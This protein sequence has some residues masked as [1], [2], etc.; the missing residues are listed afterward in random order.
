MGC[1]F[2]VVN[3]ILSSDLYEDRIQLNTSLKQ[4]TKVISLQIHP[5]SELPSERGASTGSAQAMPVREARRGT[6]ATIHEL[7]TN[8]RIAA[9]AFANSFPI[10]GRFPSMDNACPRSVPRVRRDF[11]RLARVIRSRAGPVAARTRI[12]TGKCSRRATC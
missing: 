9:P 10:R 7:T 12:E 8:N 3:P 11:V 4:V 6:S 2:D 5:A 1:C